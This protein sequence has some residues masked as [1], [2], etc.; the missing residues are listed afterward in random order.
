M[1]NC[2]VIHPLK[3]LTL[4]MLKCSSDKTG[5][6]CAAL[7]CCWVLLYKIMDSYSFPEDC[8]HLLALGDCKILYQLQLSHGW[9]GKRFERVCVTLSTPTSAGVCKYLLG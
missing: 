1:G 5:L 6:P 8:T 9:R 3:S 4:F 2:A 7:L